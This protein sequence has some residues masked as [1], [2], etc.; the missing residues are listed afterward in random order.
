M[1]RFLRGAR[2]ADPPLIVAGGG[3]GGLE[4]VLAL[5]ALAGPLPAIELISPTP[6]FVYRAMT[7]AEP[8]GLATPV[9]IDHAHL[10]RTRNVHHR[11]GQ[12]VAV[13]RERCEVELAGGERVG[14]RALI[15]AIGARPVPWLDGALTFAGSSG[16]TGMRELL[17]AL[18]AG[19][20]ED[21]VFTGPEQGGWTLPLYELALMTAAWCGE[22]GV[23][24]PRLHL[25]TPER[26]ALELF[27][28]SA[29]RLVRDLLSDRGVH[30]HLRMSVASF[31]RGRAYLADGRWIDA[32]A[33]VA[34]PRLAPNPVEGLPRDADGFIPVD[35]HCRVQGVP[36]V[37]A[38]G[39]AAAHPVKQGGLAAQ[40]A[41]VAAAVVARSLGAP[42]EAPPYRPVMRGLLLTGVTS[43]F[44]R[45]GTGP[46]AAA[47]NALWWPPTKVAGTYLAPYLAMHAHGPLPGEE[48]P[49]GRF[50]EFP[51]P[52]GGAS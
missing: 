38:I 47:F 44:L 30:L 45:T 20:L 27:G 39:D 28:A 14:Y 37:Y 48:R 4:A 22:H 36:S 41:D 9:R 40:Q 33:V 15:L 11:I 5:R 1:S 42:V 35:D 21:V 34:L 52:V 25:V 12:V 31:E 46:D 49:A 10:A 2:A 29:G 24:A 43:A 51:V 32:D 18:E 19:T 23:T 3:I 13:D 16:I 8:F 17:A 50:V 6:E 26:E 7:V